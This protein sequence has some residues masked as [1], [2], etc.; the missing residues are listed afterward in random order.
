MIRRAY[1]V[2]GIA[3]YSQTAF[4]ECHGT[5]TQVGDPV[6]TRAVGRVFGPSG[7]VLIG[8]VKPNVGHSEGASGITSLIKSV[9]T[10]ESRIIPPNIKFKEP[11]PNIQWNDYRLCSTE[12][13]PWPEARKE[14]ISVNSFG[15]GGTNAHVV[16]DSAQSFGVSTIRT[17]QTILPQLLVYSANNAESL[18]QMI[19]NYTDYIQ[20]NPTRV[21]DLAFTLGNRREHLPHRAFSVKSPLGPLTTSASSKACEAPSIVMVFTGQGA[22]WPQMES[23]QDLDSH[24]KTLTHAPEWSIEEELLKNPDA[25]RLG[26]S[27]FSQPVC[28]AIQVALVDTFAFVEVQPTAV[29]GHSSGGVAAAYAAGATTAKEAITIAF[30]RG[31]VTKLQ[32]RPGAMAAIGISTEEVQKYIQTGIIVARK[33]SPKSVTLAGDTYAIE[34][35]VARIK[36]GHPEVLAKQLKVDKAYH[37]HHMAEIGDEYY[38]LIEH[39]VSVKTP[40]KL[41]FSSVESKLF[42]RAQ[43][44]GPKYW[45][46]SLHSPVLFLSA[47]SSI[48][49]HQFANNM[50]LLEI[51]PHSALAG[52]LQPTQLQNPSLLALGSCMFS[53]QSPSWIRSLSRALGIVEGVG[54]AAEQDEILEKLKA[55]GGLGNTVSVGGLLNAVQAAMTSVPSKSIPGTSN[56]GVGI[57]PNLPLTDQRNRLIWKKDI[58]MSV[59]HNTATADTTVT[60][61]S[62]GGLET[63]ITQA[64]G[65][66]V[67]LSQPDSAQLLAVE[68][69]KILLKLEDLV[70]SFSLSELG[71]D[72]LVAIEVKQWWKATFEFDISVLELMGTGSLDIHG[73]HAARGMLRLFHGA[74]EQAD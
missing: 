22:Q 24:L 20:K 7:G 29:V 31:Q 19:S 45:Q 25:S 60:S 17:R 57:R 67:L 62:G 5:G 58:R 26:S 27:E 56:F 12:P 51:G 72:S 71:M 15:I 9:L 4:V 70:T 33:N 39:E 52:P 1:E 44:F 23:I 32:T 64:K 3:D 46:M 6:E 49:K 10:L 2:A 42:T 61:A 40:N 48:I 69:G 54:Y 41:F 16:L 53:M 14:R 74:Q 36:E 47:V 59:F 30:Y 66:A 37:S 68:I 43:N 55:A 13:R 8:S 65:D 63:F 11:N 73:E 35:A 18:Q 28:A 21:A 38:A 50:V 34:N